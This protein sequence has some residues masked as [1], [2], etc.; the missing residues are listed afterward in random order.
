MKK[1]PS[2]N[3][4][5]SWL[6]DNP[7]KGNKRDIARAFGIKGAARIDLKKLI[8]ELTAEGIIAKP[9]KFPRDSETL[10]PV[11]VL[12][13]TGP[14][15]DGDL[16]AEPVE[17]AGNAT[18]PKVLMIPTRDGTAPGTG[19]RVLARLTSTPGEDYD[20]TGRL[21]RRIGSGPTSL[22]G[23]YRSTPEGGRLI[24]IDKKFDREWRIDSADAHDARD[25]E[26]V[27]AAQTSPPGR[28][29][30]PGARVTARLGDPSAPKS[31]SLIAIHTHGIPLQ[32]PENVLTQARTAKPVRTPDDREDLRHL[33][34]VTIDPADA[35]DRDDAVLAIHDEDPKNAGGFIVWVAIADVAHYV[36]PGS[37]LD[38][39]ARRRGNS[40]YFPDRVVPMLPMDLSADLCSLHENVARP[41]L[42]VE[43]IIDAQGQKKSH[44]FTRGLI[45][46][47]ASLNYQQVQ[48]AADGKPDAKTAMLLDQVIKPLYAAFAAL[49]VARNKRQ[50]LNLD[51]PE[52]RIELA[53]DGKV[54]SVA[55]KE[56]LDAHRLIE[57]CMIKA[58]VCAAETLQSNRQTALFR[59]HEEPAREKLDA[60][61]DIAQ[62]TG[63]VLAKG[64][65]IKTAHLNRLLDGAAGSDNAETINM[66]V[67]RS[68]TQ[69]YYSPKNTGHF[70][71]SLHRY[72]HFTSPI[73]RY[74]D[75]VVHRAL[76]A[77]HGWG[78]DGLTFDEVENIQETAEHIS[79]TE[80]RSMLAERDTSD[81][82]L[83]MFLSERVGGEFSGR[84]SGIARF[85][86]FVK[87]LETGADGLVPL[88]TL[89]NEY[90]DHDANAQTLTGQKSKTR[91]ALGDP[92][93][94][95]LREA[96][97]VTGGLLFELLSVNGKDMPVGMERGGRGRKG[98][99]RKGK[100]AKS[101]RK[102]TVK[103]SRR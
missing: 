3:T 72:A 14:D 64:Q 69:A 1:I 13:I 58:N 4:L 37:D 42:A 27:E 36:R 12:H 40:T 82:Y 76:I 38:R 41:C 29:G 90:F 102:T 101:D 6:N 79:Q 39:E 86:L 28:L 67:L 30:L 49:T 51:L 22:L 85:G 23:I 2:K 20:Y 18:R 93:K 47:V 83:A 35:R 68:M 21:I 44:R 88:S 57:E 32:F 92:V 75:L 59:V 99:S 80:R 46:S 7:G 15:K 54:T 61:R 50:P 97:P 74:S 103:R 84:V 33:P 55:F 96:T 71:L 89:G 77:Q 98:F 91:I 65:V 95:K 31:V 87:L 52:R 62:N 56:R 94:V 63:L 78:E 25:G 70:G 24:P 26:L 66:A 11:S 10:P 5:I 16:I 100:R 48:S 43:M 60:L 53:D 9:H 45:K 8:R 17:W 73:R 19:D 81:R 34:L